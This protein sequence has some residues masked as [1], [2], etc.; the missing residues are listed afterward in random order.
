MELGI[1]P[2]LGQE[3]IKRFM[4]DRFIGGMARSMRRVAEDQP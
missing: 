2:V 1:D 3:H 4:T